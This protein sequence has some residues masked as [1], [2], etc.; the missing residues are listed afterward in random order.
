MGNGIGCSSYGK[1]NMHDTL[2][3][4]KDVKINSMEPN[5]INTKFVV[6]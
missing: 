6:M 4:Q 1:H 2:L 3:C 5:E